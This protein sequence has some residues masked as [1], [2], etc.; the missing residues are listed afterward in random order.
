MHLHPKLVLALTGVLLLA[1][2]CTPSSAPAEFDDIV[3]YAPPPWY[4]MITVKDDG[5]EQDWRIETVPQLWEE[6]LPPELAGTG[7]LIRANIDQRD[8]RQ[9]STKTFLR[10]C[11]EM[12]AAIAEEPGVSRVEDLPDRQIDDAKACGV[13][14]Q[15]GE[16]ENRQVMMRWDLCR[17]DGC[18]SFQLHSG[19][20]QDVVN[21]HLL[22]SLQTVRFIPRPAK[23]DD[24]LVPPQPGATES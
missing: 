11:S 2:G 16:G 3:S 21:G 1:T 5:I 12:A 17:R 14:W 13:A 20:G 4:Q 23:V 10:Y 8:P 9:P 22:S 6:P 24:V 7:M 19:P 15:Q 18:W